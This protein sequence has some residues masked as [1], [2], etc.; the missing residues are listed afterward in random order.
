MSLVLFGSGEFTNQVLDIDNF[1]IKNY[2]IKSIAILP[3]AA[4]LES[5]WLKWI[6]MAINHYAKFNISVI[7]LKV[8]RQLDA[9]QSEIILALEKSDAIFISGGN[10]LYLFNQLKSTLL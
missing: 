6:D 8:Q 2:N 7:P 9:N 3:T 4:G 10:P 1:L 5:D